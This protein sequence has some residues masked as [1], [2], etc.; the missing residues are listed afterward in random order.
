[1]NYSKINVLLSYC[2]LKL[3]ERVY[4][5]VARTVFSV[6]MSVSAYKSMLG[7]SFKLT[8]LLSALW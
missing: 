4:Q 7:A 5:R 1:M 6:K 8:I 3:K 2:C